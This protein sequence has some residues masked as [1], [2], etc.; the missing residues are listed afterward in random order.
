[1]SEIFKNCYFIVILFLCLPIENHFN[2]KKMKRK[3]FILFQ[4]LEVNIK[5][6]RKTKCFQIKPKK[7][8][9]VMLLNPTVLIQFVHIILA[10]GHG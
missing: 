7:G 8:I 6:V 10:E 2:K 1:M 5:M 3:L 4:N 9:L